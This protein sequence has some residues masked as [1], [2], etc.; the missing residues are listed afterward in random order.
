MIKELDLVALTADLRAND[1][2]AGDIGTVVLVHGES[3]GYE[4]E[5]MTSDGETIGV[6]SLAANQIRP[7]SGHEVLHAREL[8]TAK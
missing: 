4:V 6:L 2:V 5:F 7:L 1:L 8:T 3:K